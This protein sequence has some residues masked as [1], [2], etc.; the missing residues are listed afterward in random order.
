MKIPWLLGLLALYLV[1]PS[2]ASAQSDDAEAAYER[3]DVAALTRMAN[4]GDPLA[5]FNLGALYLSGEGVDK[6]EV[7]AYKWYN[8]SAA[9]GNENAKWP[10]D[11]ISNRAYKRKDVAVLTGIAEAGGLL[12]QTYLGF[13]YILG[14]G[15]PKDDAAAVSWSRKAAEQGVAQAQNNLGTMYYNGAGVTQDYTIAV[16]WYRKAA[17]QGDAFT[18]NNLGLM[19]QNGEGVAQDYV[20]AYKW[21]NLSAA[22]GNENA[23][24]NRDN[25][26]T[27][28]TS[29]QIAE[30]QRL[31]RAWVKK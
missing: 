24:T 10:R 16:S 12:A 18:Q 4:A 9:S 7:Q 20:Q 31:S 22:S 29:A 15:V 13:M 3:K 6:D 23:K 1:P 25:L 11:N 21:Y 19:Y 28:M 26:A 5:Q 8:L 14:E 27:E 17:D 30:A 2:L